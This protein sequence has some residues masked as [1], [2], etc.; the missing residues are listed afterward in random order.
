MD[1]GTII[2]L[3]IGV[4][5]DAF[6]AS[7]A[8]GITLHTGKRYKLK[9]AYIVGFA[10]GLFH[11]TMPLIGFFIGE[12]LGNDFLDRYA[13]WIAFVLLGLIG[14]KLIWE[15]IRKGE[16]KTSEMSA[17][18]LLTQAIATSIDALIVGV[19]LA[20]QHANMYVSM[21]VFFIVVFVMATLGT[22]GGGNAGFF[23]GKRAGY[24]GGGLLIMIA[25]RAL[26][27]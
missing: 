1:L 8:I 7:V 27:L 20:A 25:F 21:P 14:T 9:A 26:L 15:T 6:M 23:F 11:V 10:F 4:G 3:A 18:L 24:V 16:E 2:L 12:L 5:T 17:H 13:R 22:Y 19:V